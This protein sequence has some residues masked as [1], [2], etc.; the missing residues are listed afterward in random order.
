MYEVHKGKGCILKLKILCK[1]CLN[2][3]NFSESRGNG[4]NGCNKKAGV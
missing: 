1:R 2:I 4:F 3:N